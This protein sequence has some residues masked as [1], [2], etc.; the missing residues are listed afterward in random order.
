MTWMIVDEAIASARTQ[1]IAF[2][3]DGLMPALNA[4]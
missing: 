3:A 4:Q 1:S 2:K